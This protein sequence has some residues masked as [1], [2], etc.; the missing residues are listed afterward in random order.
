MR[1]SN[2]VKFLQEIKVITIQISRN[3]RDLIKRTGSELEEQKKSKSPENTM[4]S[5]TQGHSVNSSR[6]AVMPGG[7][8]ILREEGYHYRISGQR[9]L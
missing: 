1:R 4:S 5:G 9:I 2:L 7:I 3:T 8:L 6:E